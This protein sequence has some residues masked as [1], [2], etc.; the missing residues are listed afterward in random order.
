I[1]AQRLLRKICTKCKVRYTPDAA[2]FAGAKVKPTTT[3]RELRFSQEAL[4]NAKVRAT[5]EAM[6]ILSNITLDSPVSDLPFFKGHGCDV[7]AGT[8]LKGRQ[9]V[10]EVMFMTQT[11][12]KLVMQS[13][14]VQVLR[15]AAINEGM[16]SLRMDGW[17]KVIKG[18]TTLEQVIRETSA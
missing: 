18:I 12:K 3:L 9:G 17:L 7:C 6:P 15:D 8:G 11:I 1:L 16:L 10:Y 13:A 2:E 14:D 4:D 5:P